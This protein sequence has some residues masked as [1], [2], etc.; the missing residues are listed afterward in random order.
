MNRGPST[1]RGRIRPPVGSG[2]S[3]LTGPLADAV[4]LLRAAGVGAWTSADP[5][6]NEGTGGA[7]FD[8]AVGDITPVLSGGKF[9]NWNETTDLTVSAFEITDNDLWNPTLNVEALTMA[10]DWQPLVA[11]DSMVLQHHD[12][13]E[14]ALMG[15]TAGW[16][17]EMLDI[18]PYITAG[19]FSAKDTETGVGFVGNINQLS[20]YSLE[21]HLDVIRFDPVAEEVRWF[22]NGAKVDE[23]RG[24]TSGLGSMAP[25][26]GTTLKLM[27]TCDVWA[28]AAWDR[29]LT[30]AEVAALT[31]GLA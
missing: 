11:D 10:V 22:R 21:R 26:P 18:P 4:V 8:A 31:P 15:A 19:V 17:M 2:A 27:N 5:W 14:G 6:P 13:G 12:G 16:V 30:D 25:A 3:R 23:V 1:R 9:R 20:T 28:F 7:T 24:S 29:A